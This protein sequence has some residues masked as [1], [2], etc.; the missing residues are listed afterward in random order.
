MGLD[1]ASSP[2]SWVTSR[3][4]KWESSGMESYPSL[5]SSLEEGPMGPLWEY[6]SKTNNNADCVPEEDRFKF[7]DDLTA[8]EVRIFASK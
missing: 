1:P 5:G 7:V 8:L 3:T 2:Y 6:L 4:D